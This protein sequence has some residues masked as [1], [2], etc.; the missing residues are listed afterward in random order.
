MMLYYTDPQRSLIRLK[1]SD[2]RS[3][4]QGMITQDVHKV[5][6]SQ[7][8]YACLLSPQGKFQDDFFVFEGAEEQELF[9]DVDAERA[10]ALMTRLKMY[11]LRADFQISLQEEAGLVLAF[12]PL[13]AWQGHT[14]AARADYN[15]QDCLARFDDP[16]AHRMGQR[17]WLQQSQSLGQN[18]Q[19]ISNAAQA[20]EQ[21]RIFLGLPRAEQDIQRN[22]DTILDRAM[23]EASAI[24]WKK[25]CYM[26]QEITARMKFRALLKR[27]LVAFVAEDD[28]A[29]GIDRN[30][31]KPSE[32]LLHNQKV[33]AQITSFAW[34]YCLA[35][36]QS[37]PLSAAING[38]KLSDEQGRS[39]QLVRPPR[40]M[41]L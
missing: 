11:K 24:S 30:V 31:I 4:L 12:S 36:V 10:N 14:E 22:L 27:H 41:A 9:I 8:I 34:P 20:Y 32:T 37:E 21:L 13:E 7:A 40:N 38:E 23:D 17:I 2:A 26:G 28:T 33:V 1:G 3:F 29:A 15:P 35:L 39:W 5:S 19:E 16:R 6:A 18:Q 25:G